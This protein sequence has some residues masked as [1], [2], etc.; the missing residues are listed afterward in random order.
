[1]PLAYDLFGQLFPNLY[2]YG[3]TNF[4]ATPLL[5][6]IGYIISE[7]YSN[8]TN[9]T[10]T[11]ADCDSTFSLHPFNY[12][13][14]LDQNNEV[15][16]SWADYYGPETREKDNFTSISRYSL[17]DTYSIFCKPIS[18]Y[19]NLTNITPQVFQPE[20]IVLVQDG[21]CA[22]TCAVFTEFMK[23]QAK[24]KQ[25]VFGGRKQ[26][27]PMQGVGGVKGANVYPFS[28]IADAAGEA[29]E[30][31]GPIDQV[32]FEAAYGNLTEPVSQAML[33][34]AVGA[35]GSQLASVNVRNNIRYGDETVTPLQFVYEAADCRLFYT[36]ESIFAQSE[37]WKA[38]YA[39]TW[40]GG[41]CVAD[42][43]GHPS[44]APASDAIYSAPEQA[45]NFFGAKRISS[46]PEDLVNKVD[47]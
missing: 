30:D 32:A 15:F 25:I 19:G 7:H 36:I 26:T 39:S 3:A 4:R 37:V 18:N 34:A 13:E 29:Y 35:D 42:S 47:R 28:V 23:S 40:G 27:G 46:W 9:L 10:A 22:S 5:D 14:Q 38:A 31:A 1:M 16:T 21:G 41:S 20:N 17:A 24:V 8:T 33:R 6:D 12:R 45:R 44:S 2:P 11:P 43:T